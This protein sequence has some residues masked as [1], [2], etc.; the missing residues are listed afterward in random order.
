MKKFLMLILFFAGIVGGGIYYEVTRPGSL[1][2]EQNVFIP[3]GASSRS[4]ARHLAEANVIRSPLL[5]LIA[6]RV[7]G[8]DKHL[9]AGEYV[10]EPGASMISVMDKIARGEVFYHKITIP[11][12]WATG[13]ILYTIAVHPALSG[14]FTVDVKEGELLP[15]T[16]SFEYGTSRD[17]L[18]LQAK[19]A[20][21]KAKE[22]IWAERDANLPLKN[23]DEMV[24]L[25]SIIEKETSRPSER[26]LV[27]SVFVNRLRKGMKLQTDPT[28]IYA[29]TEGES[30]FGRTLKKKDLSVD[31]PYNTYKY[32]GLPPTPICNPGLEALY[33]AAHP[34]KSSYLYFVADGTGGHNF[35]TNLNDHNVNVR[36]WLKK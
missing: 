20:M 24:T 1:T 9:R 32:Y 31:S 16:Y 12:G 27:S 7:H 35:A 2:E 36:R 25:A 34:E 33:A 8:L 5:F 15:E 30:E 28:V 11:E 18:I 13:K 17:S 26:R 3:K 10:F 19:E 21:K 14:E 23:I 6:A 22:K 4:V 29:L